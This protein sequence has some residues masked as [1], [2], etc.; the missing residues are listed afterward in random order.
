MLWV[1][2]F[3]CGGLAFRA[4]HYKEALEEIER[5]LNEAGLMLTEVKQK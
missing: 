4:Q 1:F 2:S 3:V 5:Q